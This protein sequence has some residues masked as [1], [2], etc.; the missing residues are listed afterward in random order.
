MYKLISKQFHVSI[1]VS[2][3]ANSAVQH[4]S[5]ELLHENLDLL[6]HVTALTGPSQSVLGARSSLIF[7]E[8]DGNNT[9]NL[10]S[11]YIILLYRMD[12]QQVT[13]ANRHIVLQCKNRNVEIS[14]SVEMLKYR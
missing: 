5:P 4:V 11:M 2:N 3:L 8:I 10:N 7:S 6:Q 13:C 12:E 9:T 1:N 14:T